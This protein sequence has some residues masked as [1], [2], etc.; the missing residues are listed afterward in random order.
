[1]CRGRTARDRATARWTPPPTRSQNAFTADCHRRCRSR[2]LA[3]PR[4]RAPRHR[5]SRVT[6]TCP[7]VEPPADG[8]GLDLRLC[9]ACLK[10]AAASVKK[11]RHSFGH[12]L[13]CFAARYSRPALPEALRGGFADT[14]RAAAPSIFEKFWAA[15][16]QTANAERPST[17]RRS[18]ARL[19]RRVSS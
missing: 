7:C 2:L 3:S 17:C 18:R 9:V 14:L 13:P 16:I 1:M 15:Q 12:A 5:A 10:T 8:Q 11:P 4:I 6:D 19:P